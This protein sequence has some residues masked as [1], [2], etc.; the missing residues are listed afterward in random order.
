MKAITKFRYL[1]IDALRGIAAFLVVL[2]H[3]FGSGAYKEF[4][5]PEKLSFFNAVYFIP[6]Y[7]Y[8]GVFLFF[9]ISGFC[10]HLRWAKIYS[11]GEES[12]KIDFIAFWKRRWLRLYPAYLAAMA[13]FL[14]WQYWQGQLKLNALFLWDMIAHLLMIHNLDNRIV[15]SMNGV[16]WTLAIEEQLYLI[17]FLLLWMRKKWGWRLTLA[18]CFIM[19]FVWFGGILVLN[20]VLN[21]EIPT[22]EGALANWWIWALGALAVENFLRVIEL[23]RWCYSLT[24]ALGFMLLG[25]YI[26]YEAITI[27]DNLSTRLMWVFEPFC[28]GAGFFF[29]INRVMQYENNLRSAFVKYQAIIWAAVG[30]FSYSLYLTHEVILKV[31]AGFNS[32]L[33]LALTLIFTYVFYLIF[34]KPFM[35]YLARQKQ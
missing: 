11:R 3:L 26:H 25:A 21:I 17:Y 29:F 33:V 28:W 6:A 5:S 10:I 22:A 34:E 27:Q 12:P 15:Y 14:L 7:G 24:I 30:L 4:L 20:R 16:F 8:V 9:V 13:L 31:F 32:V 18:V 2:Y 19:R 1:N 35:L 23:P